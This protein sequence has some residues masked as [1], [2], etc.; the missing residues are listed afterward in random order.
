MYSYNLNLLKPLIKM[1]KIDEEKIKTRKDYHHTM[2]LPYD[3]KEKDNMNN[4]KLISFSKLETKI[5][6]NLEEFVISRI[7]NFRVN[8]YVS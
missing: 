6:S 4:L 7:L 5:V 2:F 8:N 3:E 1:K